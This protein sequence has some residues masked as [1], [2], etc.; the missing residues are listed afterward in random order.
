[1]SD[2]TDTGQRAAASLPSLLRAAAMSVRP[3]AWNWLNGGW[4]VTSALKAPIARSSGATICAKSRPAC[5]IFSAGPV[6]AA[7]AGVA[8]GGAD[9]AAGDA[10]DGN[11][12]AAGAA[13]AAQPASNETASVATASLM[14]IISFLLPVARVLPGGRRQ[15]VHAGNTYCA[16]ASRLSAYS[17]IV[18]LS[19]AARCR[20]PP[21]RAARIGRRRPRGRAGATLRL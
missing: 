20:L 3:S 1:M 19:A 15:N 17:L 10:D 9:N 13:R 18:L 14:M 6:G 5:L 21:R 8:T 2:C 12:D 4:S 11:W 7:V 16:R